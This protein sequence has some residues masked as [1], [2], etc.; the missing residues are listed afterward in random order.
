MS[1]R[2]LSQATKLHDKVVR[3]RRVSDMGP[4][5]ICNASDYMQAVSAT[6]SN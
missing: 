5:I 1:D 2:Q 3:L 4:I 6:N